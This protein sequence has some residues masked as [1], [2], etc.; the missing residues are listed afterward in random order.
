G[1]LGVSFALL[2]W[3]APRRGLWAWAGADGIGDVRALPLLVL[4][5][6]IF[7]LVTL[8]LQ[9]SVSRRFEREA[10]VVAIEL[11]R[12]PD[13]AVQVF[14]RLAFSNLADLRPPRIAEWILF[15]H[16]S[17]PD[18]IRSVQAVAETPATP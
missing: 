17:I 14:R 2:A 15:S 9:N 13:T 10:D 7:G 3:A 5:V 1:G 4:F 12:D 18:R 11:T 16:P 6:T 8:P